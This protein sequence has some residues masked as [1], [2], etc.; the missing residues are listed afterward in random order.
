M[1][2]KMAAIQ[3]LSVRLLLIESFSSTPDYRKR[4]KRY[5]NARLTAPLSR[6]MSGPI[7]CSTTGRMKIVKQYDERKKKLSWKVRRV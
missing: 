1:V 6:K 7:E 3:I 5:N 4:R 2:T